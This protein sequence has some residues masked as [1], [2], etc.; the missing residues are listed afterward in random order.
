LKLL[1]KPLEASYPMSPICFPL[2][3]L[4]RYEIEAQLVRIKLSCCLAD[5]NPLPFE[6]IGQRFGLFLTALYKLS[7]D[8]RNSLSGDRF[9][10]RH[11]IGDVLG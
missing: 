2:S 3:S 4:L 8:H 6:K 11:E 1:F 10:Y 5:P 9:Q 7:T